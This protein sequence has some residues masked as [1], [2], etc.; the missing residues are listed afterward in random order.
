MNLKIRKFAEGGSSSSA[1]FYQPLAMATTGVEADTDMAKLAKALTAANKKTSSDT[2]KGKLTDKD[3]LG[4]LNDV[5]GLPSDILKLYNQSL[6]YWSDPM[7]TGEANYSN[8]AQL[9]TRLSL[10][11]KIA[12]FNKETWVKTRD[13]MYANHS[14]NEMAITD[15]GQIVI[16]KSDGGLGTVSV[17]KWKQNPY[18]YKTLTNYDIMKL[19]S[20]KLPGDNSILNIVNGSTSVEA[21]T[22][23][24]QK[25]LKNAATS[26]VQSYINTDNIN[27][28]AGIEVLKG[29]A[30][31]GL[32]PTT[33]T[34]QGVYK[35][36]TKENA[37]QVSKMLQY[38]W[39]TLSTKE[40][41][42]LTARAGRGKKGVDAL[43]K[44]VALGNVS[45]DTSVDYEDSLNTDGSK[46]V[47]TTKG[48]QSD[49]Q[50]G[51][52]E[53]KADANPAYM[54]QNGLGGQD[55]VYQFMPDSSNAIMTL[56][57]QKYGDIKD[58]KDN[59][60]IQSTSIADMLS[61]S[62]LQGISDT[63]AIY[64]GNQKIDNPEKLKDIVYLN[65]GGMRVNL[66]AK[67]DEYGNKVP[68]F[69]LIPKFEQAMKK[70]KNIPQSTDTKAF[71]IKEAQ[72][73]KE[74]GL[75]NL[76]DSKGLPNKDRFGAFLVVNGK[77]S[78]DI[79]GNPTLAATQDNMD[80]DF[81]N[82]AK[83]LYPD[84]KGGATQEAEGAFWLPFGWFNS[85]IYKAPVYI[86]LDNNPVSTMILTGKVTPNMLSAMEGLYRA[87][88]I[89]IN[90]TSSNALI[91]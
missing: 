9:L 77:A 65:Q 2:E 69:D 39:G 83:I 62:G 20:E 71:L 55:T 42:L 44:L 54:I 6:T 5:D 35:Y 76:V 12:K 70:I 16:E 89:P 38:A 30:A 40:Q 64:F 63:R 50:E 73:L 10:Q 53:E 26:S 78:S 72:I 3:Y 25:V 22:D 48:N 49:S 19:R 1:F 66:P 79:V 32:D 91:N 47:T 7:A 84:G 36:T 56:Y 46:R 82:L 51:N 13:T 67:I 58:V 8:F 11:A 87:Q 17:D 57:G 21:I 28:K 37:D 14:E 52:W 68:D 4:L 60:T 23:K 43:L 34:M 18:V 80:A 33:L 75:N 41:T 27:T 15:N 74:Y 45:T 31:R 86:P 29:L 59:K 88:N 81:E 61:R 24:I 90:N 85:D